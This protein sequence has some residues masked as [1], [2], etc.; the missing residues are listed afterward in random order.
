MSGALTRSERE[1]TILALDAA[2]A[3]IA[4]ARHLLTL[5]REPALADPAETRET[6]VVGGPCPHPPKAWNRVGS[7]GTAEVTFCNDCGADIT[8]WLVSHG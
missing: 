1:A 3:S 4:T 8:E 7:F 5:G 6:A 2:A